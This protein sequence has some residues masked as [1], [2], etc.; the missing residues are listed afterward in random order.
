M[1][2]S[3]CALAARRKSKTRTKRSRK[4]K[5]SRRS[6]KK[7]RRTPSRSRSR[8]KSKC[9]SRRRPACRLL[10]PCASPPPITVMVCCPGGAK[11]SP[12]DQPA[13]LIQH[14]PQPQALPLPFAPVPLSGRRPPS[15]P[16]AEFF[17]LSPQPSTEPE[18]FSL[19]PQ[20]SLRQ[21]RPR[22]E[23]S[24]RP[25][26]QPSP[27]PPPQVE[28]EF[29]PEALQVQVPSVPYARAVDANAEPFFSLP[30]TPF[31]NT[32][33][34]AL[35]IVP[36]LNLSSSLGQAASVLSNTAREIEERPSSSKDDKK[37]A[38]NIRRASALLSQSAQV[39]S[40]A[41]QPMDDESMS[42]WLHL[43]VEL[44]NE[45]KKMSPF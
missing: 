18:F 35:N 25:P 39:S 13:R 22:L 19:P 28:P 29:Y 41:P 20:P 45:R 37:V 23:P 38:D 27:Q 42:R 1:R 36:P 11:S 4:S 15:A 3:P 2:S 7:H 24:P 21:A 40:R 30:P 6:R 31:T 32:P 9:R 43:M 5:A 8:R 12:A 17:S 44:Y 14:Q 33:P 26:S 10:Q 16:E 34:P